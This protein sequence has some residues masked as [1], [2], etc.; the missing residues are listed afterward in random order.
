[1][2][3]YVPEVAVDRRTHTYTVNENKLSYLCG[4]MTHT[5]GSLTVNIGLSR[6]MF[7]Q[8]NILII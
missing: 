4:L 5:H 8:E 6:H 2:P 1:M 3:I 7:D